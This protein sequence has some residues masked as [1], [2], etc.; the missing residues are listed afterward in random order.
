MQVGAGV[1]P[2]GDAVAVFIDRPAEQCAQCGS[3]S[4]AFTRGLLGRPP[5][6]LCRTS[7]KGLVGIAFWQ[8]PSARSSTWCRAQ[9]PCSAASACRRAPAPCRI[10]PFAW[11]T[12]S[13]TCQRPALSRSGCPSGTCGQAKHSQL[14]RLEGGNK[15]RLYASDTACCHMSCQHKQE[16]TSLSGSCRVGTCDMVEEHTPHP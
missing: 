14:E 11:G 1:G 7:C 10:A 16:G 8:C 4:A 6:S 15:M 12:P 13:R 9:R 5:S 2:A 3:A